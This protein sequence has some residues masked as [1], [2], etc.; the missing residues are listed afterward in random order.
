MILRNLAKALREQNWFTV[1]LEVLIVVVG[2][3]IG[4]QADAWNE[5]RKDRLS[6]HR[7]LERIHDELAL[8]IESIEESIR[9]AEKSPRHGSIAFAGPG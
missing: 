8:D 7:Y 4:L 9:I 6:E 3:F 1:V 5:V 2:I